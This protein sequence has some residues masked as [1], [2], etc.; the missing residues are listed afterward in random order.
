MRKLR[1]LK[2]VRKMKVKMMN[3]QGNGLV[4]A[5]DVVNQAQ[6]IAGLMQLATFL[7]ALDAG[8]F[9]ENGVMVQLQLMDR[10][11]TTLWANTNLLKGALTA[12]FNRLGQAIT[13]AGIDL[14]KMM[15]GQQEQFRK[16][17][18]PAVN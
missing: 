4:P 3:E 15:Q 8:S 18:P 17:Y 6:Q 10:Q 12:E 9:P 16:L 5:E 2:P 14:E 13:D 11:R 1:Q 7:G